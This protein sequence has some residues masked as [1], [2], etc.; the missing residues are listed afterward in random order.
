MRADAQK[1]R[2]RLIEATVQLVLE[3]GRDPPRDAIAQR[4]GVG[5]ATLYRHF[6]DQQSLL[7]AVAR[8]VLERSIE[9]G[10]TLV[11]E[12]PDG[13][14]ALRQYMHV[15]LDSGIG[16]VNI[17]HP[18]I[19]KPDWPDLR[20]RATVLMKQLVDGA[21]RDGGFRNDFSES[22]IVFALTRFARPLA[23]GLAASKERSLSHRHLDFYLD[24][25]CGGPGRKLPE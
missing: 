22:D 14:V 17:I 10:E 8:G 5:I 11:R 9:A 1:N 4:A 13:V 6:P 24:G 2:E 21:R 23:M 15:A 25:L 12:Q 20:T 3:T 7:L 19:D 18:L 16:V